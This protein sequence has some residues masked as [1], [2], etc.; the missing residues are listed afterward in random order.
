[1]TEISPKIS[2]RDALALADGKGPR[3]YD[4]TQQVAVGMLLNA[5]Q[6]WQHSAWTSI[7]NIIAAKAFHGNLPK[8]AHETAERYLRK[9]AAQT[10]I[11]IMRYTGWNLD[12]YQM[13]LFSLGYI[14]STI[15]EKERHV[16]RQN[17]TVLADDMLTWVTDLE[18]TAAIYAE[19][20]FQHD[21]TMREKSW[22]EKALMT[23]RLLL[24]GEE[25][26]EVKNSQ[27]RKDYFDSLTEGNV[28]GALQQ[29][30]NA[31]RDAAQI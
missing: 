24:L 14:R 2:A 7:E 31:R 3:D 1:M 6:L 22:Y 15:V 19:E 27:R 29:L 21:P 4:L 11:S 17:N 13:V 8:S 28:R 12:S 10:V 9:T 25:S 18:T 5:Q 20:A 23:E 16:R 30:P 26:Q